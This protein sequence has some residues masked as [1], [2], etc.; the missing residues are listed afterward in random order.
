MYYYYYYYL[1][2]RIL[3]T[4]PNYYQI[5]GETYYPRNTYLHIYTNSRAVARFLSSGERV[6]TLRRKRSLFMT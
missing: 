2:T 5:H 4:M 6:L 1:Q 3:G